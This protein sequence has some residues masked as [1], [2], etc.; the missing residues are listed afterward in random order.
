MKT[1]AECREY[2]GK[3]RALLSSGL[4]EEQRTIV[5]VMI[6]IW[7]ALARDR[8]GRQTGETIDEAVDQDAGAS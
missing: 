1:S 8:E 2:A 6:E 5:L 3:C 4:S 7:E